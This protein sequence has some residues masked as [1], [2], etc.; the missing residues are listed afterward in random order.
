MAAVATSGTALAAIKTG[1]NEYLSATIP[2]RYVAT[3]VQMPAPVPLNQLT[4][5]TELVG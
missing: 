5:A 4:D 2:V 3:T 1:R